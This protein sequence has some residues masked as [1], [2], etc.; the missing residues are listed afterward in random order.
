MS[1]IENRRLFIVQFT[2]ENPAHL[3]PSVNGQNP[4]KPIIAVPAFVIDWQTA[5]QKAAEYMAAFQSTPEGKNVK[6][7]QLELK[8]ITVGGTILT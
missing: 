1:D 4:Q 5:A 6:D 8:Q 2:D 7:A 3:I